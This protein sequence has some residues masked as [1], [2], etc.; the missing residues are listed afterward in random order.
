MARVTQR[1]IEAFGDKS[2]AREWIKRPNRTFQGCAPL[3]L[4]STDAG[5]ALV[6]DE[7][8]R[9]EYGDLY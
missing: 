1:A 5:A 7:L 9:I 4:L 6:T 2:Q 3:G 8:G